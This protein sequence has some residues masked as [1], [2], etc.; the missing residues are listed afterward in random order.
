[1]WLLFRVMKLK[2]T[3]TLISTAL[4]LAGIALV[5]TNSTPPMAAVRAAPFIFGPLLV[6]ALLGLFLHSRS[7]QRTLTASAVLF[8][9]AFILWFLN[10]FY[11]NL[12]PQNGIALLFTGIYSLPAM[13]PFWIIAFVQR[14]K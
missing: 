6:T 4:V 1:M 10:L 11:W 5:A 7:S 3:A 8:A 14:K 9:A 2:F 12:D 13:I